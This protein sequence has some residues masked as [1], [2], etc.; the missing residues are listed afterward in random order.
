MRKTILFILSWVNVAVNGDFNQVVDKINKYRANHQAPPVELNTT[1]S[2]FSQSWADH[3]A[4]QHTIEQ[5]FGSR[6]GESIALVKDWSINAVDALS[7]SIDTWYQQVNAYDFNKP[8]VSQKDKTKDFTQMIWVGTER[9]GF[10]VSSSQGYG[11]TVVV[12]YD[13]LGNWRGLFKDNVK[14]SLGVAPK[15]S[16]PL[17]V[18]PSTIPN[19]PPFP[20]IRSFNKTPTFIQM[21]SIAKEQ[22]QNDGHYSI[23]IKYPKL[24]T[25]HVKNV[26]CPALEDASIFFTNK[27][28]INLVSTTG[29][30]YGMAIP[31][32]YACMYD[33]LRTMIQRDLIEF[34]CNAKLA[35]LSTITLYQNSNTVLRY[36]ASSVTCL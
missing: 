30:Y 11:T 6:Y 9:I 34:T 36:S 35:C 25:T 27:C 5:S 21:P 19:K 3:S 20:V 4:T 15:P 23:S 8:Q 26:L 1:I 33:A 12:N 24:N 28:N 13:P 18:I 17:D 32:L 22:P 7:S 29:I 10:G 31:S 14:P 2:L 16:S